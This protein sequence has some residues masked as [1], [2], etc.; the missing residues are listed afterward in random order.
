MRNYKRIPV[1][2]VKD[3][4]TI[5]DYNEFKNKYEPDEVIKTA[6]GYHKACG[7]YHFRTTDSRTIC[8]SHI[9]LVYVKE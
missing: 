6:Q 1:S 5:F 9:T 4:T 8:Y 3:R 7:G 2:Q